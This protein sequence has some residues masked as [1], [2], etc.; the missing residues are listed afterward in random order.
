MLYYVC[1]DKQ[2]FLHVVTAEDT[3]LYKREDIHGPFRTYQEA[4]DAAAHAEFDVYTILRN[5][6][7]Y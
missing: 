3:Y 7:L 2:S 4:C 1:M 5:V 6:G